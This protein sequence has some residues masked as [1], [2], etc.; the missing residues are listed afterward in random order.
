[1]DRGIFTPAPG[2]KALATALRVVFAA[3]SG[4]LA[5]FAP[6]SRP[7]RLLLSA[8]LLLAIA[9]L[10]LLLWSRLHRT[11]AYYHYLVMSD[12][13]REAAAQSATNKL[14][15][16]QNAAA[17]I[18][19]LARRQAA[20]NAAGAETVDV[21]TA[22]P[23]SVSF[24]GEELNAFFEKW[25]IFLGWKKSYERYIQD[26]ELVMQEGRLVF[27]GT[28]RDLGAV[29]TIEVEPSLDEQGQLL[30]TIARVRIG[31]L[32]LPQ[33]F[34]G[35]YRQ[36]LRDAVSR[37]LPLWQAA[38]QLHADGSANGSAI[39]AQMAQLLL[40]TLDNR[41]AD[42]V[43]FLPVIQRGSMPVRLSAVHVGPDVLTLTVQPMNTSESQRLIERIRNGDQSA[44]H[45]YP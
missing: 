35:G 1:M 22:A 13:Q 12:A 7:K 23:I 39:A 14:A 16:L 11:P 19:A 3:H 18:A 30:L 37:H 17:Q 21:P 41:P 32:P 42:P 45:P 29:A 15:D 9:T 4:R 20:S 40:C 2:T 25:A 38:A 24:S 33:S 44:P 34:L 10:L 8:V 27:V 31:D 36:R 43:I 5:R 6:M 28:A 26:P